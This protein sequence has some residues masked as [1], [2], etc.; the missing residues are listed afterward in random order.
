MITSAILYQD[1]PN[2]NAAQNCGLF[3]VWC[4]GE[5]PKVDIQF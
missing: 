4:F 3:H 5:K 1:A 2:F